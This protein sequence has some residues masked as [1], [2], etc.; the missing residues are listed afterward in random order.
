[1]SRIGNNPITIPSGVTVVVEG[2]QIKVNGSKGNLSEL[3]LP[4]V[5]VVLNDGTVVVTRKKEDQVS[6]AIHGLTRTL[7]NNMVTGVTQGWTKNLEL[8]GVGYRAQGGGSALTL[9][10]GYSHPVSFKAPEG[11][12]FSVVDNTK[13]SISGIDKQMV[14]QI[15]ANIRAVRPPEVYKGKGVRYQGEYVRRKAGKA[16]KAGAK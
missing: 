16:G 4:Q 11:I 14:G 15:A 9:N 12:T 13:I 10:V 5:S 7:I 1:M 8:V 2:N 3:L 6:K